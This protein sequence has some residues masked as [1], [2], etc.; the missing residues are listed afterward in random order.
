MYIPEFFGERQI[1]NTKFKL[2]DMWLF[3]NEK[4]CLFLN[5]SGHILITD[6]ELGLQVINN[7]CTEDLLLKLLQRGFAAE[8]DEERSDE[9]TETDDIRPMFFM[10]DMTNRCN[11][12]CKY[13]L[14]EINDQP[15]EE[16]ITYEMLRK[17]CEYIASYCRDIEDDR[18]TIQP[19]GGEPLLEKEKIFFI[20]NELQRYGIKPTITIETNGL[21][22]SDEL[23]KELRENEIDVSVSI[24]GNERV[25]DSQRVLANGRKTHHLIKRRI[26]SFREITGENVST[27]STITRNSLEHI[28]DIVSFLVNEL[29]LTH[30][31]LNFVHRSCFCDNDSL[32]LTSDEIAS[33]VQRIFEYI[34]QLHKMNIEVYDYNIWIKS[35][36]LL[37][38][39]KLDVCLSN[40]CNGGR[41]MI[42]IDR[43][44][45][46]YPCDVT[47]FPEEKMG[48]VSDD[49]KLI[50]LIKDAI[51]QNEYF[52]PKTSDDCQICPW[53][54]YCMGGCTVHMKCAGIKQNVDDI[55]CSVNRILYP[56][57]VE[58]ILDDPE[59]MNRIVGYDFLEV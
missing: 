4:K 51:K 18:I 9:E 38:A 23:I 10:I 26:Q 59:M 29:H 7:N 16:S 39:K 43:H 19:W 28:E 2:K 53:R 55:E 20:K 41:R 5:R 13:C 27:I 48:N 34:L 31:K 40:G 17:I 30:I 52:K 15:G 57:L 11:M 44:G 21:L 14:R 24:D 58:L 36:N 32:C 12:S 46:I 47:D 54:Y 50:Q 56:K 8:M 42:T 49:K 6:M 45:D 25:H 3:R 1:E 35:M 33:V 37:T 22:L